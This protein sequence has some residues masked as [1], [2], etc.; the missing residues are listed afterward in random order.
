[1]RYNTI[2]SSLFSDRR[3]AFCRQMQSSSIAIFYSNDPKH[4]SA[5]QHY[6]FRQDPSLFAMSG[7]DQQ[8]TILVLMRGSKQKK[9]AELL[10]ILDNDPKNE[11]WNGKRLSKKEA[12]KI[13]A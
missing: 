11:I 6:P 12:S 9:S 2:P 5:D 3:K 1:M 10:F 7:I 8:G 4:R 13:S